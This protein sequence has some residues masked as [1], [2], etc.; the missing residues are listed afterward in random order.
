MCKVGDRIELVKMP[1]DPDPIPVGTQG[2]VTKIQDGLYPGATEIYVK[3]DIARSL[4]L[5][6]P[7]DEYRVIE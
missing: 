4:H 5:I 6:V 1:N 3:W 7:P 2:T